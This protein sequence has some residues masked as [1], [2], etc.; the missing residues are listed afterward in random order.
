M[1]AA[2]DQMTDHDGCLDGSAVSHSLIRVDGP[3]KILAVAEILNQQLRLEDTSGTTSADNLMHIA[4]VN[5]TVAQALLDWSHGIPE[6]VH[7][8]VQSPNRH[9][10]CSSL[11]LVLLCLLCFLDLI[12]LLAPLLEGVDAVIEDGGAEHGTPWYEQR[13]P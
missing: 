10:H 12:E 5:A 1:A 4:L 7:A 3:A 9:R 13:T 11:L 8:T 2:M 6:I